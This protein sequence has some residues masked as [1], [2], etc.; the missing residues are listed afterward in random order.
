M[1]RIPKVVGVRMPV[2]E[3]LWKDVGERLIGRFSNGPWKRTPTRTRR[4][5]DHA[6]STA[7]LQRAFREEDGRA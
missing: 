7:R 3:G 4:A 2:R 1:P 6:S 5:S